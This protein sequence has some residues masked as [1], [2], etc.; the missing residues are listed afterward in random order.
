MV[1][2]IYISLHNLFMLILHP[3]TII[4]TIYS[5]FHI[6]GYY[7]EPSH[8]DQLGEHLLLSRFLL[9]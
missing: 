6:T 2:S 1:V 3:H 7:I 9:P 4:F 5:S 8:P